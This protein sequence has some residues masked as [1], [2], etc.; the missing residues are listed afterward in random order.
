MQE[1][2]VDMADGKGI[3]GSVDAV[4]G[5]ALIVGIDG[6][7]EQERPMRGYT[8]DGRQLDI[9]PSPNAGG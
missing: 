3:N 7:T 1:Q 9:N 8:L 6:R 5:A 4:S 2:V